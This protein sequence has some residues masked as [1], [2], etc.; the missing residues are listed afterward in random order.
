MGFVGVSHDR[1]SRC[2]VLVHERL[3]QQRRRLNALWKFWGS[4][5]Y[6]TI[7]EGLVAPNL[8]HQ[9]VLL[10]VNVL[11]FVEDLVKHMNLSVGTYLDLHDGS[12]Y[13]NGHLAVPG[14]C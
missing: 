11:T 4:G 3:E 1:E 5:E 13:L 9:D 7:A 2:L 8:A 14:L 10:R 6:K 12:Q